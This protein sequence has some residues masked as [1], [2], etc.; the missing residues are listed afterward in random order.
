MTEYVFQCTNRKCICIRT[1]L[2][3]YFFT[4]NIS[5]AEKHSRENNSPMWIS[6]KKDADFENT[7]KAV[8]KLE[9]S[10]K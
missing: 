5:E 2:G 9:E 10:L 4:D 1:G 6:I 7:K 8:K 3:L